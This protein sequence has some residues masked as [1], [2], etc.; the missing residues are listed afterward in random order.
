MNFS[1]SWKN[2][3]FIKSTEKGLLVCGWEERNSTLIRAWENGKKGGRPKKRNSLKKNPRVNPQENPQVNPQDTHGGPDKIRLDKS[4]GV[5]NS[6]VEK[7]STSEELFEPKETQ[8]EKFP[9]P[10]EIL[11]QIWPLATKTDA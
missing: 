8:S 1:R 7:N 10:T 4:R 6:Y 3:G 5:T 9:S 2:A 11:N